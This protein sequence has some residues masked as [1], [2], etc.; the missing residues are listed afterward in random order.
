MARLPSWLWLEAR[1]PETAV[2]FRS[3]SLINLLYNLK[4]GLGLGA[5]PVMHG[6]A[7]PDL[8][9]CFPPPPELQAELWLIV[10]EEVKARPHVRAFTDYLAEYVRETLKAPR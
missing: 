10:R 5:M 8:V 3:N 2:R 6:D 4:A 9:L 7:D 1:A